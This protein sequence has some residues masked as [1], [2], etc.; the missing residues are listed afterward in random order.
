MRWVRHT[1]LAGTGEVCTE[2][3]CGILRER[4]HLEDLSVEGRLV[5]TLFFE[6]DA[7]DVERIDLTHDRDKWRAVM[8]GKF[9]D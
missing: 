6:K 3:W 9:L 5:L 7:G 1:E 8:N 2:F 4:D